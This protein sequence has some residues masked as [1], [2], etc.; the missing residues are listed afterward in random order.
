MKAT[1][2][3]GMLKTLKMLVLILKILKL[4]AIVFKLIKD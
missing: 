2:E 4:L 1:L 3:A